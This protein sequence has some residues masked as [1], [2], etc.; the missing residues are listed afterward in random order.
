MD[1]GAAEFLCQETID[2]LGDDVIESIRADEREMILEFIR[3]E[4]WIYE[5]GEEIAEAI[6]E[7]MHYPDE[8]IH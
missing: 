2:A 8:E 6:E 5:C 4:E 7:L 3:S 1:D